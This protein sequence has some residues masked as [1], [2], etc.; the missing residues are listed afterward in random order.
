MGLMGRHDDHFTLA[1]PVMSTG[2]EYVSFSFYNMHK[3]IK[4]CGML[5]ETLSLVKGVTK[6]FFAIH[7]NLWSTAEDLFHFMDNVF[8]NSQS[9][10][11]TEI[12]KHIENRKFNEALDIIH[13]KIKQHLVL[14]DLYLEIIESIQSTIAQVF[15]EESLYEALR[16]T[17]E[18]KKFWFDEVIKLPVED[19]VRHSR[20]QEGPLTPRPESPGPHPTRVLHASP[21]QRPG[22]NRHGSKRHPV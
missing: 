13:E 9:S 12:E 17:A 20:G 8:R 11:A 3:C 7:K 18:K 19:L 2:D 16:E 15:G 10:F 21:G 4:G 6:E 1:Y 14:H 5:A 22:T